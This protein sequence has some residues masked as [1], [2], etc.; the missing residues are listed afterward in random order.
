MAKLLNQQLQAQRAQLEESI[1]DLHELT[2]R[3]GHEELSATLSE[4]RNRLHE[5]FMFVIVGEVKA[6]KSSFI[7]ALLATGEEITKV[8]PQPMTDTI[9]QILYGEERAEVQVNEYLKK[10]I[11]PVDILRD[12]AIVDTPGTNTIVEH[13][14]EIT[15][16]F[17]PASDLIVFVFEAKNPY[18]QSAWSFFDFIQGEWRKKV[19]F[20]L[21]QKDLMPAEDL[22]INIQGVR[23]FALKKGMTE[24]HIF[25]VS[26]KQEQE[27]LVADSGFLPLRNYITDNITGG[28]APALKLF[29]S[30]QTAQNINARITEGLVLR[31]QQF[32]ADEAFRDQ[33]DETLNEQERKSYKQVELLSDALLGAYDRITT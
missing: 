22:A 2:I 29:N 18:R 15:E 5:P 9:Q 23:D 4:L 14:Q 13:H 16:R 7:N 8:A 24:P 30:V 21:Q 25:A 10:I 12:I 17:V 33:I 28:Q 6:G 27:G 26:A 20:V 1:K 3:I 11:L 32:H 31:R 19:I